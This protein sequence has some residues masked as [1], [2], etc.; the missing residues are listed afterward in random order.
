MSITPIPAFKNLRNEWKAENL[1]PM[2]NGMVLCLVTSKR[3]NGRLETYATAN[4]IEK[5]DDPRISFHTHLMF[6]DFSECVVIAHDVKKITEKA[7]NVQH[8][9]ACAKSD[10][11]L[12]MAEGFYAAK[13]AKETAQV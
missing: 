11:W 13:T 7:V 8:A 2:N 6:E 10:T 12:A 5:T 1:I 9:T 4:R 3:S